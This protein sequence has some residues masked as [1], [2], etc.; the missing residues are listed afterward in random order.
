MESSKTKIL[1][2]IFLFFSGCGLLQSYKDPQWIKRERS[3]GR[4][5]NHI[6]SCGPEAL[7]KA[8]K[9]LGI[10]ISGDTISDEIRRS[11][12]N[13]RGFLSIFDNEARKITFIGEMKEVL[14]KKGFKMTQVDSL[15]NIDTRS[16]TSILLV[17]KKNSF[18]Y[19][20]V[21][22]PPDKFHFFGEKTVLDKV[23]LIE[24]IL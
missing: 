19:H 8:F 11:G 15:N 23:Y 17:H 7:K 2:F 6:Y 9:R 16:D 5:P 3:L 20:W 22:H 18:S 4:D 14:R 24:K 21:C 10:E 12:N 13:I 1:T